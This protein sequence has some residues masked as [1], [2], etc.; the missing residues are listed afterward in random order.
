MVEVRVQ[1]CPYIFDWAGDIEPLELL[2]TLAVIHFDCL[3]YLRCWKTGK[4]VELK[5][6]E[7]VRDE[8]TERSIR[9]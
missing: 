7:R 2:V 6:A 5:I 4:I 1:S 8:S 9:M 3:G